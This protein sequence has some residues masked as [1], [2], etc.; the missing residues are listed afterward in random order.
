MDKSHEVM[1]RFTAVPI[2]IIAALMLFLNACSGQ[3]TTVTST[4]TSTGTT[5]ITTTPTATQTSVT[6][7]GPAA[8]ETST[9]VITTTALPPVSNIL[10]LNSAVFNTGEKIPIKYSCQGDNV[11]PPFTW[12]IT[13]A[14]TQSF[15]LMV[16][17]MD[18]PSG[19]I[20]HWIIFN[21][22]PNARELKEAV[23]NTGTLADGSVQGN[24]I[25]G[26]YGYT[27]PCPPA[28]TTH[29]YEFTLFALDQKLNLQPGAER[30]DVITAMQGHIIAAAQTMGIFQR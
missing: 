27:G 16:E 17:D 22:P 9:I 20:T 5:I 18:G 4:T 21:I 14:G 1:K 10:S 19:I 7:T 3:T 6:K 25:R 11:S 13:P 28:G 29:R 24:N 15:A 8:T 30:A 2:C 23:P 26:N 12:N